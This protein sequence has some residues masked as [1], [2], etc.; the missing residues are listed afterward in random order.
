M[1]IKKILLVEDSMLISTMIKD[2]LEKKAYSICGIAA[3]GEEAVSMAQSTSPDLVLMDIKLQ[4][5]MNGI[6]ACE[7]IMKSLDIPVIFVSAHADKST[8]DKALEVKPSGYLVKPFKWTQL[9]R[10]IEKAYASK[11]MKK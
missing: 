10:E 5:K 8:V 7:Q 2:M 6:A 4:G 9:I 1:G 3:T 11:K